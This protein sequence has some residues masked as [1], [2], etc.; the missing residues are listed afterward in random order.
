MAGNGPFKASAEVQNELGFP[1]EKVENWQQLAIDKM[2]E[3]KSKYRS[4]QVFLD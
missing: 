2:A 1:G 4:V 3:T